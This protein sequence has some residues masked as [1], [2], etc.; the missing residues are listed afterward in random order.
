MFPVGT[1]LADVEQ[2]CSAPH[3]KTLRR[4]GKLHASEQLLKR[5]PRT[6]P[7]DGSGFVS[8]SPHYV[9]SRKAYLPRL[10]IAHDLCQPATLRREQIR[11]VPELTAWNDRHPAFQ[12]AE[13]I[14]SGRT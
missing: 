4:A 7:I 11:T 6:P 14:G 9:A 3:D 13:E 10:A 12:D 1:A 5:S 2:W 8:R